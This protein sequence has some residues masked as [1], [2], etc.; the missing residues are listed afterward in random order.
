[1][2]TLHPATSLEARISAESRTG[3]ALAGKHGH[4]PDT[5]NAMPRAQK[6]QSQRENRL[7]TANAKTT[8]QSEKHQFPLG[9]GFFL[10]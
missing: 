1:M 7:L 2:L 6:C 10:Q 3:S 9:N 5:G 8:R 4:Q